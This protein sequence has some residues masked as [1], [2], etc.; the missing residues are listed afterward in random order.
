MDIMRGAN[1]MVTEI[2]GDKRPPMPPSTC[3]PDYASI[4]THNNIHTY[5]VSA[6]IN[7]KQQVHTYHRQWKQFFGGG[8]VIFLCT[9]QVNTWLLILYKIFCTSYSK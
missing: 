5:K 4:H 1:L 7:S 6:W 2:L 9:C 8:Q 3:T